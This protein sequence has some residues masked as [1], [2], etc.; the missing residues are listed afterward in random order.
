MTSR[1]MNSSSRIYNLILSRAFQT[2]VVAAESHKI[3]SQGWVGPLKKSRDLN[4]HILKNCLSDN[5]WYRF[6]CKIKKVWGRLGLGRVFFKSW[7]KSFIFGQTRVCRYKTL[8]LSK[9]CFFLTLVPIDFI[10]SPY[11]LKHN[12]N[13]LMN[14]SSLT[15]T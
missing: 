7:F 15:T 6:F 5:F 14:T 2:V 12:E 10:Y 11:I 1:G 13:K 3:I 8:F 4:R 9:S